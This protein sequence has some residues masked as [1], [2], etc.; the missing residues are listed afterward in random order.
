MKSYHRSTRDGV[1]SA[2]AA[3]DPS[4]RDGS[5]RGE[6]IHQGAIVGEGGLGIVDIAGTN[7]DSI[8]NASGGVT[9]SVFVVVACC[10][11]DVDS[12]S[13]EL[14]DGVIDGGCGA[15]TERHGCDGGATGALGLGEDVVNAGDAG[16]DKD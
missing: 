5:T 8:G 14:L 11:D 9:G 16:I 7:S 13:N 3:S 4:A 15:S 12:G 2:V 10:Y 1:G 6:D